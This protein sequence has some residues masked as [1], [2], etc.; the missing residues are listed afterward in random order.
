[1]LVEKT[2]QYDEKINSKAQ[3]LL[4][5]SG[6]QRNPINERKKATT[7]EDAIVEIVVYFRRS[8]F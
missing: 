8:F 2:I 4:I 1:M 6:N 5:G 3:S 7:R